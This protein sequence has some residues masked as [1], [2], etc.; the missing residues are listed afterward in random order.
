MGP[1]EEVRDQLSPGEI[2]VWAERAG[3]VRVALR[4]LPTALF[5]IP[6]L[7]FALFWTIAA[8]DEVSGGEG[9][10]LVFPLFGLSFVAI[11]IVTVLSPIW[12]YV[13]GLYTLYAV[14]NRRLMIIR[15]FPTRRVASYEPHD[16]EAVER[17]DRSGGSG[18]IIFGREVRSPYSTF[19]GFASVKRVGFF[20]IP[21]VRRVEEDIRKL[22]TGAR[23]SA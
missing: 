23:R 15:R 20:G 12:G 13:V 8:W 7:A 3:A 5:G 16:I 9:A 11:S 22:K 19:P 6:F 10:V 2:A 14:T 21:E 18:D 17:R 4:Y 1:L